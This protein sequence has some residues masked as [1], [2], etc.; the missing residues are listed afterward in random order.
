MGKKIYIVI[1]KTR[2]LA[3]SIMKIH[4]SS[5]EYTFE[6]RKNISLSDTDASRITPIIVTGTIT[7]RARVDKINEDLLA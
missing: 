6:S 5:F 4:N 3:L 1:N 2:N 7:G